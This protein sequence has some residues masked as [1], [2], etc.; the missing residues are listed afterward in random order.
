M[1]GPGG[2]AAPHRTKPSGYWFPA[3]TNTFSLTG[4]TLRFLLGAS[5]SPTSPRLRF[6]AIIKYNEGRVNTGA[7]TP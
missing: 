7:V 3:H 2:R 5:E 1:Q 6:A 4:S